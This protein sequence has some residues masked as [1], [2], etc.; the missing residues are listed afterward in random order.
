ME[1]T[2]LKGIGPKRAALFSE[3]G[4]RTP[5]DLLA[6]YPREY[7]DYSTIVPIKSAADG[8]RVSICVTVQA[9]PTMYYFKGKYMVSLRVA[10]ASGKA[11]FRW[12][13]QPYRI[14]QFHMGDVLYANAI[15]LEF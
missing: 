14:N 12:I 3:L 11:T 1:L 4:I 13:N 6:F 9:D 8:E 10:D 15:K 2:D 7:L 5:E